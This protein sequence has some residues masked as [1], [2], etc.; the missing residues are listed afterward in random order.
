MLRG[1]GGMYCL[2]GIH[3]DEPDDVRPFVMLELDGI[4]VDDALDPYC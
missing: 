2:R 4:A 3:A 1:F